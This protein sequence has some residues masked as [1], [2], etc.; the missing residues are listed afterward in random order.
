[1]RYSVQVDPRKER[2]WIHASDGCTVGRFSA[3]FGVDIHTS[4]SE[5]SSGKSQCLYCTHTRPNKADW[6]TFKSEALRLWGVKLEDNIIILLPQQRSN[7]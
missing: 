7:V 6:D 1:M 5:Q 4:T 3:K 2:V